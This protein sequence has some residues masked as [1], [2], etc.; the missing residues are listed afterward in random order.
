MQKVVFFVGVLV[1]GL[2]AWAAYW[3][4]GEAAQPSSDAAELQPRVVAAAD[5][6]IQVYTADERVRRAIQE[7]VQGFAAEH[8]D[9]E[10]RAGMLDAVRGEFPGVDFVWAVPET[11]LSPDDRAWTPADLERALFDHLCWLTVE[12]ELPPEQLLADI[13][14]LPD[15]VDDNVHTVRLQGLGADWTIEFATGSDG[16]RLTQIR[17]TDLTAE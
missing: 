17:I 7:R 8:D 12:N 3:L 6:A 10:L 16:S 5:A 2:A 15:P 9:A 4:L 11:A 14:W 13:R 1:L